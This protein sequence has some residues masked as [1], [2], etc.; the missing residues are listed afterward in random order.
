M[1]LFGTLFG[2]KNK[3]EVASP[4]KGELILITNVSDP[5]FSEEMLGKGVALIPKDGKFFAPASGVLEALFPTGHAFNVTTEEGAQI[6]VH[7]GLETV[8]LNGEHFTIHAKQGDTVSKG[9]LIV[10]VDI[11]AVKAAGYDITTPM[12]VLNPDDFTFEKLTGEVN[13][14]DTAL[15]LTKA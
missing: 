15:V 5:T 11:D 1:G 12:I 3:V 4:V 10:E 9:D 6:L 7:I 2:N 13:A 14:G 8:K